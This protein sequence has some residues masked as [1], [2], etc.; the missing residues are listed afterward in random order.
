MSVLTTVTTTTNYS[1]TTSDEVILVDSSGGPKTITL[2]GSH[3]MG[4]RYHIKDKFGTTIPNTIT[5][6]GNGNTIDG[7]STFVLTVKMQ[8][9]I[10]LSDGSNWV[11]L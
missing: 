5:I 2:P 7:N 3:S 10:V 11:L 4:E 9:V 1:I 8:G 6:S